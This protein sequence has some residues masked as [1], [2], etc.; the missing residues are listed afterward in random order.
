[1]KQNVFDIKTKENIDT[2]KNNTAVHS[3]I[4]VPETFKDCE[5]IND[6]FNS[7]SVNYNVDLDKLRAIVF[8]YNTQSSDKFV[9]ECI[10]K[11]LPFMQ[12]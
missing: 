12:V 3:F 7:Y 4:S 2:S 11:A 9:K 5:G 1:M 10:V 8:V 6:F